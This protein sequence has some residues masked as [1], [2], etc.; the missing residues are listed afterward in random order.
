MNEWM[1]SGRFVDVERRKINNIAK[2]LQGIFVSFVHVF[3]FV[4]QPIHYV[5][6]CTEVLENAEVWYLELKKSL[7]DIL[8][9]LKIAYCTSWK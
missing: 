5:K 8:I 1:L 6:V 9:C 3:R 2:L 4:D 7:P